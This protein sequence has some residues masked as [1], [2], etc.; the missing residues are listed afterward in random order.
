MTT[1]ESYGAVERSGCSTSNSN[2]E[3]LCKSSKI[4]ET[5]SPRCKGAKKI[6][7]KYGH[8]SRVAATSYGTLFM[9]V[10]IPVFLYLCLEVIFVDLHDDFSVIMK[11]SGT[12]L[13]IITWILVLACCLTDPGSPDRDPD[14]LPP[15]DD[16]KD[17]NRSRQAKLSDGRTWT[18]KWC[19][20]CQLWRPYR[21]GHC[22][23]CG[24]CILRL[25]HH[26]HVVGACIGERNQRFFVALLFCAGIGLLHVFVLTIH[27]IKTHQFLTDDVEWYR[28]LLL[29][30]LTAG[31]ASMGVMLTV[32]GFYFTVLMAFDSDCRT[33][34][35]SAASTA[36]CE[37]FRS[38]SGFQVYCCGKLDWNPSACG[39]SFAFPPAMASG[40]PFSKDGNKTEIGGDDEE[41]ARRAG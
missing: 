35:S 36:A 3:F 19:R 15:A 24:R 33:W 20:Q 27:A 11:I 22:N 9:S 1:G 29:V 4:D 13:A 39:G 41:S 12:I 18:Q 38:C 40:G 25:D 10:M 37:S 14:D 28:L 2:P 17:E 7:S 32:M 30:D 16:S 8:T 21:C 34:D 5:L 31:C 23:F 6:V 26:C